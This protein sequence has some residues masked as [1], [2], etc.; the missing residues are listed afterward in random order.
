MI[1]SDYIGSLKGSD[2]KKIGGRFVVHSFGHLKQKKY[3]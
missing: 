1:L 2:Q 3:F